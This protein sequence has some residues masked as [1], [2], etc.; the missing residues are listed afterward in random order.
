MQTLD[1][2]IRIFVAMIIGGIIGY[3]REMKNKSA[4]FTTHILVCVGACIVSLIQVKLIHDITLQ[5]TL[6]P[7]L[8]NSLKADIGR[9]ISQVVTGV[10]FL[11]AG[12]IMN[13]KGSIKGLTTAATLWVTACVGIAVG[14]G[15]YDIAIVSIIVITFAIVVL[16][17]LEI[18]IFTREDVD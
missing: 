7:L 5:I 11:G 14:L 4:G 1:I 2:I 16:K 13:H 3:E 18:A 17:K 12:S 8:A 9:V 15:Y 6:N 10:G